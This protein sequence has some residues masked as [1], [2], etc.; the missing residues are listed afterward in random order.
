[1]ATSSCA[2]RGDINVLLLM[3]GNRA[4]DDELTVG[5]TIVEQLSCA[6]L[7]KKFGQGE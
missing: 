4:C 2:V 5:M 1:M 6:I 7:P 3:K